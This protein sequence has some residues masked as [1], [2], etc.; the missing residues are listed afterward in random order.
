MNSQQWLLNEIIQDSVSTAR[1]FKIQEPIPNKPTTSV[2]DNHSDK[3]VQEDVAELD[4]NT[5]MNPF[6]TLEF[7]EAESS[8]N[9]QDPSNMHDYQNVHGIRGSQE[10]H[11]LPDRDVKTAFLNGPLKEEVFVHQSLCGIFIYQ[12]QYTLELLKKHGMDGCDSISTQMATAKIYAD[13]QGTSTDQT[14]YHSI[15]KGLMYLTASRPDI[16]FVIFVYARY[17]DSGFELIAYSD[18]D[19]A[20]CLADYKSTSRGIQFL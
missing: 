6:R 16:A 8:S 2:L 11:Y 17:Q 10:L 9:Y 1:I 18:A 14:K 4:G 5:F 13:L 3:Q 19:L 15:I 20:G 12:S 7:K